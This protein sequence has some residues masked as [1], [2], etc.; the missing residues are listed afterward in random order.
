MDI[1]AG[2]F[3]NF[4]VVKDVNADKN[5]DILVTNLNSNNITVLLGNGA[6]T[7]NATAGSPIAV[8]MGP[9]SLVVVDIDGDGNPDLVAA[10]TVS[11]NLSILAGNGTGAFNAIT[12]GPA[13]AGP[14]GVAAGDFNGDGLLDLATSN[15]GGNNT[16]VS[17]AMCN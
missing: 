13:A 8:G 15:I 5:P 3:S 2:T 11:G 14:F 4:V 6:G 10:N 17:L 7:F 9:Q 16:S 12:G 1:A